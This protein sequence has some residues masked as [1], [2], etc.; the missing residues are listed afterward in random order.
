MAKYW[1][2]HVHLMS[3]DPPKTAQFYEEMFGAKRGDVRTF[4]DGRISVPLDLNG[5]S[6]LILQP[7]DKSK[8]V[9][10]AAANNYGLEHFGLRTDNLEA[11]V[12][13][14]KAKGVKFQQDITVPRPGIKIAFLWAPENVL[15]EL[16][17]RTG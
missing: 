5:Q 8:A 14:L 10:I 3:P 7:K 12:K 2:D 17:E 16:V 11:A 9:T 13:D 1:Y 15:I 4:P 6:I